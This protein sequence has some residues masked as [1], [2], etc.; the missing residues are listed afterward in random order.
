MPITFDQPPA[1]VRL[2][3][4][5]R[6]VLRAVRAQ[7][8]ATVED[9]YHALSRKHRPYYILNALIA[10]RAYHHIDTDAPNPHSYAAGWHA[11]PD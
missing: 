7:P 10:L 8:G 11:R 5:H 1:G 3:A 4:L 2:T 6:K 9:L